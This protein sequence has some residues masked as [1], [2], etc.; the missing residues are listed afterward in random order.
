MPVRKRL[1]RI[2]SY[3]CGSF[4]DDLVRQAALGGGDDAR[5]VVARL[6][7]ADGDVVRG[8]EVIAHEILE[9]D[10]DIGA[11]R[12]QV[13]LAQI[14]PVEQDAAFV[15]IVE[16]RQQLDQRGLAGA[17]LA[18]QREDLAGVQ[19]ERQSAHRPALGAGVAESHVL[20]REAL[21]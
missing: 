6:D 5:A 16:P 11:N 18:H 4:A 2:W 12:E 10:A 17:V 7:A 14:V 21:P 8:G 3:P 13:V 19:L 1:P 15:R 20:E 9:D